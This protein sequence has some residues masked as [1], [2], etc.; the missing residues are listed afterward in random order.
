ML[1]NLI[2]ILLVE[3]VLFNFCPLWI[4]IR[5]KKI[6]D[7]DPDSDPYGHFWILDPDPHENGSGSET[8]VQG[9]MTL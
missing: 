4:R 6:S 1:K 7:L 5:I 3:V 9:S 8:L 2:E